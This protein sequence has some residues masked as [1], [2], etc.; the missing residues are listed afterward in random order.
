MVCILAM[1][2]MAGLFSLKA[3]IAKGFIETAV[4]AYYGN[5]SDMQLLRYRK[6]LE[7][8]VKES[9]CK[10]WEKRKKMSFV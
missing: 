10:K 3:L 5:N 8:S 2:D 9:A 1:G 6:N 4:N 7:H